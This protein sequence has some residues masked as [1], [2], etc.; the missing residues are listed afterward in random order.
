MAFAL[1]NGA[2]AR[3]N[4]GVGRND[5]RSVGGGFDGG[6]IDEIEDWCAAREDGA[7]GEDCPGAD[8]GSF[9]DSAVSANEDVVFNDHGAGVDGLEYAADLGGSAKVNALANLGAGS[10]KGVRIDH[11]SLVDP[12]AGVDVTGGNADHSASDVSA[13][14]NR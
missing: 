2:R 4:D 7:R 8:D 11:R 6:A 1:A 14:T 5:E 9:V 3:D 13:G 10:D 12:G